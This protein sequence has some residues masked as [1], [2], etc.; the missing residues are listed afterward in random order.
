MPRHTRAT[1][2][3]PQPHPCISTV[4]GTQTLHT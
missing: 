2:A 4:A 3:P 1:H